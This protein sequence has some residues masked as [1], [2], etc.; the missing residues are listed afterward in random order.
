MTSASA[1]T[2]SQLGDIRAYWDKNP[3]GTQFRVDPSV[4]VGSPEFFEHIRPHMTERFSWIV[5]LI[6]ENGP[7]L[8]GRSLLEIGC[9][10]GFDSAAWAREGLNVSGVD[11]SPQSVAL[12]RLNVQ[13]SGL[14]AD[15][16]PASALDL[17]FEDETFD[18]VYS[19][20]VLHHTGDTPRA[21]AEAYRVLKPGG[22]AFICHLYR[23]HSWMY[24]ISRYGREP[25]EF[26]EGDP[27][28]TVFYSVAEVEAMFD[29]FKDVETHLQHYRAL[30][31]LRKGPKAWLYNRI[32][33]PVF[34][35]LPTA[36]AKRLAYKISVYAR[37]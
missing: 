9:G 23:R 13:H 11:L 3:L 14:E 29:K 4:E 2:D 6:R 10:M 33:R 24:Y 21:V 7:K 28:V 5:D 36:I 15:L 30:K 31:T 25:I 32:F 17:P 12:A 35:L 18:V 27:P 37:K 22:H 26:K 1:E 20:G 19:R 8:K 16:K 34:N